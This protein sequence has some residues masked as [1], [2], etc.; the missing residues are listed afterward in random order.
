MRVITKTIAN[1]LIFKLFVFILCVFTATHSSSAHAEDS[2]EAIASDDRDF[3]PPGIVRCGLRRDVVCRLPQQICC[4]SLTGAW[5]ST[6]SACT[7]MV[8]PVYCDGPED[9]GGGYPLCCAQFSFTGSI[10]RCSNNCAGTREQVIMCHTNSDCSVPKRC[11]TCTHP[12][13]GLIDLC[14][15]SCPF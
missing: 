11:I 7:G 5:C 10:T 8:A 2:S 4:Q 14:G 9:C 1:D 13:G 12:G 6:P 15:T 3:E